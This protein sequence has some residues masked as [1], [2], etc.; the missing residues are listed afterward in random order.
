MLPGG[1]LTL[2][3]FCHLGKK[4]LVLIWFPQ[5]EDPEMRIQLIEEMISGSKR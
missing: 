4:K 5:R 3:Y 1:N 2:S